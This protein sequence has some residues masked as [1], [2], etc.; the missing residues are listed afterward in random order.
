MSKK[1]Y[2]LAVVIVLVPVILTAC[3][4][5]DKQDNKT[6]SLDQ[7]F[8]SAQHSLTIKYPA[9]WAARE[10][11]VAVE[12]GNS[13]DALDVMN[14]GPQ[15]EIPSGTLGLQIVAVPVVEAG[16]AGQPVSDILKATAASIASEDT[17]TGEVTTRKIGGHDG[18]QVS[19]FNTKQKAEGFTLG[20]MLNDTT[21]VM[22]V[23]MA[24]EGE[25]SRYE[26]TAIKIAESITTASQP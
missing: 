20:F 7:T 3:G 23:G 26:A 13:Q 15:A 18:A 14:A 10:G 5:S 9:G 11:D 6:V 21:L 24:H 8:T 19:V 4:G 16:L 22:V 1:L 25:W 17:T 2:G 12:L